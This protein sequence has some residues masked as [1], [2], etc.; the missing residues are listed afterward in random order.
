MTNE[1]ILLE[2]ISVKNLSK[3]N[4]KVAEWGRKRL[5]F[6]DFVNKYYTE[7][8]AENSVTFES[9]VKNC[10]QKDLQKLIDKTYNILLHEKDCY[11]QV[12]N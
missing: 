11:N 5:E 6:A 10:S 8:I 1:D 12:L 3:L 9:Y 7:Y 2:N 4:T